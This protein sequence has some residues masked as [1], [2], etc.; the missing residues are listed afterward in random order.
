MIG[1]PS[2]ELSIVWLRDPLQFRYLRE[3]PLSVVRRPTGKI[4]PRFADMAFMVGYA[5][6]RP[7]KGNDLYNRRIWWLKKYDRD[8]DPNGVYGQLTWG[9]GP[10]PHE[11]VLPTS[12]ALNEESIRYEGSPQ[13]MED[14]EARESVDDGQ[15]SNF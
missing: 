11:A 10:A 6:V 13:F 2:N 8:L 9:M 15:S 3:T 4:T 14:V 1:H 5:T 7:Q 12:I